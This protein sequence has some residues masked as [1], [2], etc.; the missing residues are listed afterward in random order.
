MAMVYK[1]KDGARV[2]IDPQV[3]GEE[4]DR[5]RVHNNGRLDQDAIVEAA[6]PRGSPLHNAFEWRDSVAAKQYRLQQ[7]GYLIRS[8]EVVIDQPLTE[9]PTPVR[10]FVNVTRDEDRSYTSTI[11]AMSDAALRAQVVSEALTELEAWRKRYAELTE[12]AAIFASIDEARGA[13]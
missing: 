3:A 13:K 8:L 6:R 9:R 2:K 1:W 10:A 5:I 7:A 11:H 12:L 4:L